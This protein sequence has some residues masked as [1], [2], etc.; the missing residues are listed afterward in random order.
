MLQPITRSPELV[1]AQAIPASPLKV[2]EKWGFQAKQRV[3]AQAVATLPIQTFPGTILYVW[4]DG[5]ATVKFD[6]D[7]SFGAE[8]ELVKSGRVDL[9][10]LT[11]ISS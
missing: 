1:K 4:E 6:F 11:R 3:V 9:H 2:S 10:Y 7:I 5:T 8:R